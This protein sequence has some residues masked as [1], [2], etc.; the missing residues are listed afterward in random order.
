MV[1]A[2]QVDDFVSATNGWHCVQ[3][4]TRDA[5]SITEL[6]LNVQMSY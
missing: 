2:E 5:D 6:K 3:H 4:C 1:G